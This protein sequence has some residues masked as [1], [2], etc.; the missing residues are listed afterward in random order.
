MLAELRDDNQRLVQSL[1]EAH[2]VCEEHNDVATASFL[3]VYIDEA[4]RR[5][6]CLYESGRQGEPSGH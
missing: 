2:D 6:W 4:E 1:R 5:V 3:E